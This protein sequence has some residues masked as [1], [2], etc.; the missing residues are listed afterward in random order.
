MAMFMQLLLL[1]VIISCN[2]LSHL[3]HGYTTNAVGSDSLDNCHF[4]EI[5][6]KSESSIPQVNE[7]IDSVRSVFLGMIH[8]LLS[9]ISSIYIMQIS[10]LDMFQ[11]EG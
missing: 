10:Q 3:C 11:I 8:K 1:V 2:T 4:Q 6:A 5:F 7:A 9:L